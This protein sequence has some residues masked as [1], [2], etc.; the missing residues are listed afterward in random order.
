[1]IHAVG[2]IELKSIA[3][4]VEATD[5][6]LKSAGISLV[7]GDGAGS[8]LVK[9]AI[10][11]SGHGFIQAAAILTL[12]GECCGLMI[13]CPNGSMQQIMTCCFNCFCDFFTA[14]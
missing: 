7:A 5:D 14:T 12:D 11:L 9:N 8:S 3:K 1:M 13:L 6:A 4:G 10:H 2:V